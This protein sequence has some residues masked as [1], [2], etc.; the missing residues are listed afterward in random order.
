MYQLDFASYILENWNLGC[1][2]G[3]WTGHI[4]VSARIMAEFPLAHTRGGSAEMVYG[5][6]PDFLDGP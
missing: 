6:A 5:W 2:T 1:S 3:S 4:A